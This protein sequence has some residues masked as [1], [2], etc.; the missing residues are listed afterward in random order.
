[1]SKKHCFILRLHWRARLEAS[2]RNR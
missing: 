2:S 1:M